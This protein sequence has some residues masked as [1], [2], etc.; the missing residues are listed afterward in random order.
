MA[1]RELRWLWLSIP[2]RVACELVFLLGSQAM[3]SIVSPLRLCWVLGVCVFR[4]NQPPALLAEWLGS[5]T[6]KG[7]TD[8]EWETAQKV[9]SGEENSPTAPARTGTCKHSTMGPALPTSYPSFPSYTHVN[10]PLIKDYSS[11]KTTLIFFIRVVVH[12]ALFH[13]TALNN[14]NPF[15][16]K[17]ILD[18][19]FFLLHLWFLVFFIDF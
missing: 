16:T 9:N 19:F 11:F 15:C 13:C 3:D 7:G 5:F 17:V 2:R 14:G 18:F 10:E 1:Q 12:Q 4:C 8:T 6:C